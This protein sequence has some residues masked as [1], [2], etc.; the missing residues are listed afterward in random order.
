MSGA[1]HGAPL[2]SKYGETGFHPYSCLQEHRLGNRVAL[3]H[4]GLQQRARDGVEHGGRPVGRWQPD[5]ANERA[6]VDM[7]RGGGE[8]TE[9]PAGVAVWGRFREKVNDH[10]SLAMLVSSLTKP[11]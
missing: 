11:S 5:A 10:R 1:C 3:R 9:A 8:R 4:A 2:T 6:P 7:Q